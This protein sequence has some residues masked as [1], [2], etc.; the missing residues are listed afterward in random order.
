M[1]WLVVAAHGRSCFQDLL[2][3]AKSWEVNEAITEGALH[4]EPGLH[5]MSRLLS[6]NRLHRGNHLRKN[7]RKA[8]FELK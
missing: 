5:V 6:C 8:F 4:E 7:G 1:K 2:E 3:Q